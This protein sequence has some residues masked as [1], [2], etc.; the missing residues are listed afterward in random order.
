M[1]I[2]KTELQKMIKEAL[3]MD[4][5]KANTK[6]INKTKNE[7]LEFK[8]HIENIGDLEFLDDVLNNVEYLNKRKI[9]KLADSVEEQLNKVVDTVDEI[10]DELNRRE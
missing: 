6:F 5:R 8:K 9:V 10:I 7:L 3:S 2:T 1:K 4:D